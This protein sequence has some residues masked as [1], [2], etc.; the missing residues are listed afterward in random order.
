MILR[1]FVG[2][3]GAALVSGSALSQLEPVHFV[4][5]GSE[6]LER[7]GA[8]RAPV[9]FPPGCR[10]AWS[11]SIPGV[12]STLEALGAPGLHAARV[13]DLC[14][15]DSDGDGPGEPAL[16]A[17][18]LFNSA[19]GVT[20]GAVARWTGSAWESIGLEAQ[21]P[22]VL[23]NH[24]FRSGFVTRLMPIEQDGEPALLIGGQFRVEGVFPPMQFG[25]VRYDAGGITPELDLAPFVGDGFVSSFLTHDDGTGEKVFVT[26][27][28]SGSPMNLRPALFFRAS[29]PERGVEPLWQSWSDFGWLTGF[30]DAVSFDDGRGPAL[31]VA[32][33]FLLQGGGQSLASGIVGLTD[34]GLSLDTVLT[35]QRGPN[36]TVSAL[37]VYDA[38][39]WAGPQP[40]VLAAGGDFTRIFRSSTP[41]DF[42]E[43]S[44]AA[45][46]DGVQW[47]ALGR[48]L[49]RSVARL[50]VVPR[51]DGDE[52]Y[53]ATL[54][55][56]APSPASD[57]SRIGVW[58]YDQTQDRWDPIGL[59]FSEGAGEHGYPTSAQASLTPGVNA[60]LAPGLH[61]W[62]TLVAGGDFR[63]ADGVEAKSIAAL[64]RTVL[65]GDADGD[66]LVGMDDITEVLGNWGAAYA[67]SLAV[68]FNGTAFVTAGLYTGPGDANK[69][70]VVDFDDIVSVLGAWGQDCAE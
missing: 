11:G 64:D 29:S 39:G 15:F 60:L 54:Y 34:P 4:A 65:I 12:E 52:L 9:S 53:A 56:A 23:E 5:A 19:N 6:T 2:V 35:A 13:F 38:D 66:L 58:K 21:F 20:A 17:A 57:E 7:T 25:V 31:W 37:K 22:S 68:G 27:A 18:G 28:R 48:N 51:A 45:T 70:S 61:G 50:L 41:G 55:D 32:G 8:E 24:W 40:P 30:N 3:C 42:I 1:V 14:V 43:V 62:P 69:D 47:R 44:R 10:P 16:Y 67:E 49:N 36:R 33:S 46:W 63:Y 26:V 59:G